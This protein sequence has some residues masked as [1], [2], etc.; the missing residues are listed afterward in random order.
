MKILLVEDERSIAT[1]IQACYCTP[2]QHHCE[3][4]TTLTDALAARGD[5]DLVIIDLDLPDSSGWSTL[6]KL[7]ANFPARTPIIVMAAAIPDGGV[8]KAI[9]YGAADVLFKPW[10]S[11]QRFADSIDLAMARSRHPIVDKLNAIIE[12]AKTT[13]DS[14]Q[15]IGGS[16]NAAQK[17]KSDEARQL[18]K[19][20]PN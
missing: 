6:I 14:I 4:A 10:L 7:R 9:E 19:T 16:M 18:P 5:F 8:E 11:P 2:R 17:P 12:G 1:L 15:G 13:L 3:L 20:P